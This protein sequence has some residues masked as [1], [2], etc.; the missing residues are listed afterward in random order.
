MCRCALQIL[1]RCGD[2]EP[3]WDFRVKTHDLTKESLVFPSGTAAGKDD[4]L[5]NGY[6]PDNHKSRFEQDTGKL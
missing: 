3:A 5:D 6:Q 2:S 1:I 4:Q